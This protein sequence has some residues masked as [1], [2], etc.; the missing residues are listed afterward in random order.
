MMANWELD[1]LEP[2]LPRLDV[3]L[4]LVAG[5]RDKA[6]PPGQARD[7]AARLPAARVI[8]LEGGHLVHEER[9]ETVA[10]VICAEAGFQGT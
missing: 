10:A 1:W 9:S 6:V 8:E 2:R 5:T 4:M 7:L 3:P